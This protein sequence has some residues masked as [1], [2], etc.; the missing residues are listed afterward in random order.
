MMGVMLF[1]SMAP[2]IV[3]GL[4]SGGVI[5]MVD[6]K[7]VLVITDVIRGFTVTLVAASY[8]MGALSMPVILSAEVI[9]SVCS[10]FFDPATQAMI[11]QIVD[12]GNL[13]KANAKSQLVNGIALIVGPVLGGICAAYLGYG[14]V[15][16]F[17]AASF[18][19]A[20]FTS[21]LISYHPASAEVKTREK[22]LTNV[23]GGFQYVFKKRDILSIVFIVA[24]LHFFVGSVQVVMPVFAMTLIG[25]GAQN[26]G[27]LEAFYGAG[28]ILTGLLLSI[29]NINGRERYFMIGGMSFVGVVYTLYGLLCSADRTNI[30]PYFVIFFLM[31]A[32]VVVISTSYRAILQKNIEN[33][34]A[35]RVF[36]IISSVGNFTYPIAI[37]MVG[38]VLE[39]FKFEQVLIFCGLMIL[40]FSVFIMF[41]LLKDFFFVKSK[42]F[43]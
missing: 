30:L 12:R 25:N 40:L 38:L 23:K 35:G 28:I 11:P 5:D 8:F 32:A 34:M 33:D 20:S 31:S 26:L 27:N 15:F 16:L 2:S 29:V 22:L 14:I 9:L 37:L 18:L 10:A 21:F 6:R 43:K 24:V 13:A 42:Q 3:V 39:R 4:F 41:S 36:G 7:T 1:A 19:I 17:N